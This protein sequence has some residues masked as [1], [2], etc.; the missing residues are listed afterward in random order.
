MQAAGSLRLGARPRRRDACHGIITKRFLAFVAEQHRFSAT[1]A[2][3]I[4]LFTE[5]TLQPVTSAISS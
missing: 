5:P 4:R 1:R 2:R 3:F